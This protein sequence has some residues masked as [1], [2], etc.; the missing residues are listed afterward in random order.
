M[1]KC[2]ACNNNVF[3][4]DYCKYHQWMR[5]DDKKPNY[6]K[7]YKSSTRAETEK[8]YA[9][10][11]NE[12]TEEIKAL[13][14][15]KIYCFFTGQE[16]SGRVTYHHLRGRTGDYYIDKQWLVPC[17]NEY[18]IMF[19][20]EPIEKLEKQPWWDGFLT[21]LREK[22]PE[23]YRKVMNKKQKDILFEENDD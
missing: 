18:H 20:Q 4:H 7:S 1:K 8:Y 23:S 3:S 16:I 9:Q 6:K 5:K 13:N 19:H 17:I 2:K 21:R 10:H 14:K 22:D 15:G 12:L 11:C